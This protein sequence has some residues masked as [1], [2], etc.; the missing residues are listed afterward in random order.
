MVAGEHPQTV[1]P[2]VINDVVH[3]AD[4]ASR[5]GVGNVPMSTSIGGCVDMN[6]VMVQ[7]IEIFSP[8][9]VVARSGGQMQWTCAAK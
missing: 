4:S 6:F 2:L 8:E 9:Y 5:E 3:M 7:V 1:L